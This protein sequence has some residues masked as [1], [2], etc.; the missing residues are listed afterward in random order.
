MGEDAAKRPEPRLSPRLQPGDKV[1]FV[2]PASTPDRAGVAAAVDVFARLG[3]HTEIAPH[4]FDAWGYLAGRDEDRLADLNEAFR[5][6]EVRAVVA[7]RG[8][9][10]AYR[11]ADGIDFDAARADPKPLIGFSEITILHMALLKRCGLVGLHGAPW[12]AAQFGDRAARS[13][14]TA[15]LTT[16]RIVIE[17]SSAEP[18]H[19]LTTRGAVRGILIGG[20]QD[21]IAT[22]AGWALPRLDGAILLLEGYNQRLGHLDRQL[23]MLA[24][25]GALAGVIGVA[26]GQY[27]ECGADAD[28]RGGWTELDVLRDRL[29]RLGVPILG[30]LPIGHGAN[31]VALPIGTHAHLDVD[32]GVLTVETGVF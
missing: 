2:S 16:D 19:A 8:G 28:T 26:V 21:S 31:P 7:T 1:R 5:D 24:N 30:G 10:G 29:S 25:C 14:E 18:T 12:N 15:M 6:P 32:R 4:A 17:A 27:T 20:N 3:I 22:S 9:K 11:I 13:I 23:T